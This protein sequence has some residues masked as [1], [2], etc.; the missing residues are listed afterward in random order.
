MHNVAAALVL[1]VF[2][3][4]IMGHNIPPAGHVAFVPVVWK[5]KNAPPAFFPSVK[6]ISREHNCMTSTGMASS[7]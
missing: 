2:V 4:A 1:L 7:M 6:N 5:V 3:L